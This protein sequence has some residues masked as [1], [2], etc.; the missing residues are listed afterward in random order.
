MRQYPIPTCHLSTLVHPRVPETFLILPWEPEKSPSSVRFQPP[1]S[2][3]LS[4]SHCRSDA[5]TQQTLLP[6]LYLTWDGTPG[7]ASSITLLIPLLNHLG[8]TQ[9]KQTRGWRGWPHC[10]HEYSSPL[11]GTVG[12]GDMTEA[13]VMKGVELTP[14]HFF[15][16]TKSLL[17]GH[18]PGCSLFSPAFLPWFCS[19]VPGNWTSLGPSSPLLHLVWP[20]TYKKWGKNGIKKEVHDNMTTL[21]HPHLPSHIHTMEADWLSSNSLHFLGIGPHGLAIS[22][23][24]D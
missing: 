15:H 6:G 8:K 20:A 16:R 12:E 14:L 13:E 24:G 5:F 1:F 18:S 2:F 10:C 23:G 3:L 7:R 4:D 11:M 21:T 17:W 19:Q 22:S 9:V